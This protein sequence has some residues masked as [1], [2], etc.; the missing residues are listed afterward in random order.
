MG[1]RKMKKIPEKPFIAIP[2][3]DIIIEI[4]KPGEI[5]NPGL[6]KCDYKVWRKPNRP[7]PIQKGKERK[8]WKKQ[9]F[10]FSKMGP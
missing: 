4:C 3:Y 1:C 10:C 6:P 5:E 8:R 9:R 2:K 7:L